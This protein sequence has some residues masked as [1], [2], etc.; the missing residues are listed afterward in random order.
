[1]Q[2]V[3]YGV[4]DVYLCNWPY[5]SG[6]STTFHR[7]TT[8]RFRGKH[9]FYEHIKNPAIKHLENIIELILEREDH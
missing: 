4:Q 5:F 6:H 1:M 7:G 8:S 9:N 2:L 3:A